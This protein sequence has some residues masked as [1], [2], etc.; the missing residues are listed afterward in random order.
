MGVF[1]DYIKSSMAK[2]TRLDW[3]QTEAGRG[4]GIDL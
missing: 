4:L 3:D 1:G 2:E